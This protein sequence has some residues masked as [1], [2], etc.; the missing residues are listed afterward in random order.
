M[1][2]L[3]FVICIALVA[4]VVPGM[5]FAFTP[6]TSRVLP[7]TVAA[8]AT[9]N[10]GITASGYGAFCQVVETLPA[11]FSY[12]SSSLDPSQVTVTG[13]VVKF[14]L[15]AETSFNYNVTASA[16]VGSKTFSGIIKDED[17]VSH[18][19]G[20]DTGINVG[21]P[22]VINIAAI[23]GVTAPVVGGTP[24]AVITQT[25]QYTGTVTWAPA[26]AT[27]AGVTVYTATITLTAKADFTLTG[28]PANFFTVAGVTGTATNPANSGVITAV[29][30]ATGAPP[31]A[32]IPTL[33]EW[34]MII[35]FLSIAGYAA[36]TIKKRY[37]VRFYG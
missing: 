1:R 36:I 19:I 22:T 35:L 13:N 12:V 33:N 26:A 4:L 34:G 27:F 2:K 16:I 3:L 18:A 20:G 6:S 9:F 37:A 21:V 31:V 24:V 5:V 25:A 7:A 23:P 32:G 30:P 29:F 14:I 10:V 8:G 17:I 11:G 15:I 28:V